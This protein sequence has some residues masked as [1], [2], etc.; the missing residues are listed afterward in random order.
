MKYSL[1]IYAWYFYCPVFDD[2]I[3]QNTSIANRIIFQIIYETQTVIRFLVNDGHIRDVQVIKDT[4][5]PPYEFI[6]ELIQEHHKWLFQFMLKYK[7]MLQNMIHNYSKI[8]CNIFLNQ[9]YN[10]FLIYK[11]H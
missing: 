8:S 5:K 1:S 4:I 9:T 6:K 3:S 2:K 11:G 10:I 7:K